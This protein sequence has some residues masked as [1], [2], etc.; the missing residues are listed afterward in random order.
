MKKA[1]WRLN[2][3]IDRLYRATGLQTLTMNNARQAVAAGDIL[4]PR[5]RFFS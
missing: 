1:P 3:L 2:C 5:L 4:Y